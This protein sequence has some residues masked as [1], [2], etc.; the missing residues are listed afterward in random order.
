MK[1]ALFFSRTHAPVTLARLA[2][3][4]VVGDALRRGHVSQS[5]SVASA[6]SRADAF[7]LDTLLG[8]LVRAGLEVVARR[9]GY[10]GSAA[11]FD[12]LPL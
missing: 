5:A 11:L 8:T 3:A 12:G 1:L 9:E 4:M 7:V 2:G 10:D 6:R